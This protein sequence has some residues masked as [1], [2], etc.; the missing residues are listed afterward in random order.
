MSGCGCSADA[1]DGC[2]CV[3]P[4]VGVGGR[5]ALATRRTLKWDADGGDPTLAS[6]EAAH[7]AQ[8][9]LARGGCDRLAQDRAELLGG[10]ASRIAEVD[11]V[12]EAAHP[13]PVAGDEVVM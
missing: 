7:P 13:H 1:N 8:S 5:L 2:E 9:V 12:V 3:R 10:D 11:L 6:A 4:H